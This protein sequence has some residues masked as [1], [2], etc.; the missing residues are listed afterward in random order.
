MREFLEWCIYFFGGHRVLDFL[1]AQATLYD[2]TRP[3]SQ[4]MRAIPRSVFEIANATYLS[5]WRVRMC[6]RRLL[7]RQLVERAGPHH[8]RVVLRRMSVTVVI[9]TRNRPALLRR[10]LAA[11]AHLGPA[12]DQVL[13][14]DNTQGDSHTE[15]A[16][17]DFGARYMIAPEHG[18]NRARELASARCDTDAVAY[19]DDDAEP[20]PDWLARGTS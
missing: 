19:L 4:P 10:C 5:E 16:A 6:L 13:V 15:D 9:C 17:R 18:L 7:R 12:P 3:R 20:A 11:V 2:N 8:W 14:V 1:E